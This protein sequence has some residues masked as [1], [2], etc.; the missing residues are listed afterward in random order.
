MMKALNKHENVTSNSVTKVLL[1]ELALGKGI[2]KVQCSRPIYYYN[3][4]TA[5]LT[6][7][8]TTRVSQY[9]KGKSRK[10]KTNLDLLEQETVSGDVYL[11]E[12]NRTWNY[13][14]MLR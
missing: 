4:F 5:P 14:S 3:Y 7:S 11:R 1:Q 2:M 13:F 10:V 12:M 6:L 8:G 9:L